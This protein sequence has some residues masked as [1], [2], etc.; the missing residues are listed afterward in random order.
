MHVLQQEWSQI[1]HPA[2]N[3][4]PEQTAVKSTSVVQ[5]VLL[6]QEEVQEF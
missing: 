3:E 5:E 4:L 1:R 2:I 6:F